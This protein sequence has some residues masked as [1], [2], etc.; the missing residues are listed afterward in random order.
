MTEG[1]GENFRGG[2]GGTVS[3]H[4]P[5]GHSH[6]DSQE[7]SFKTCKFISDRMKIMGEFENIFKNNVKPIHIKEVTKILKLRSG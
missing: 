6:I 2:R 5:S 7:A 1:Y 4:C 3:S